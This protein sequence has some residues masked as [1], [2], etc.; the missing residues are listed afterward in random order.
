MREI[1]RQTP[2]KKERAWEEEEESGTQHRKVG[3]T[4]KSKKASKT[5]QTGT[6]KGWGVKYKTGVN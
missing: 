3:A 1:G 2:H 6:T 5:N 4:G